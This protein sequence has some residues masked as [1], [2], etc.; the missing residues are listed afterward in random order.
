[1]AN[2]VLVN[3]QRRRGSR[4]IAPGRRLFGRALMT[5]ATLNPESLATYSSRPGSNRTNAYPLP[6]IYNSIGSGLPSYTTTSCGNAT[7]SVNGPPS[8]VIGGDTDPH[9]FS[10]EPIHALSSL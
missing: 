2:A 9:P 6:G 8:E 5:L 4:F 10:E 1:M 3:P 7:P